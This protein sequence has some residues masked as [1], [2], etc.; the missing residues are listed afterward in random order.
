MTSW[1]A[2][3]TARV[4]SAFTL[5]QTTLGALGRLPEVNGLRDARRTEGQRDLAALSRGRIRGVEDFQHHSPRLAVRD[6]CFLA[7]YAAG[8]VPH[9]LREAVIPVFLEHRVGPSLGG[10]R[11]LDGIAESDL[12]I[13]RERVAHEDVGVGLA[14]V[15]EDLDAV[16]HAARAIPAA[17]DHPHCA[18]IELDDRDRFVLALGAIGMHLRRHLR[19]HG[20]DLRLAERPPAERDAVA[21]EVHDR[22]TPRLCDVP[23][24]GR[25]R[26]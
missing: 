20:L 18:V 24:P 2:D 12:G 13:G 6:R 8:E 5:I 26:A 15:A 19:V 3:S 22:A 11:L 21:A 9:L 17:F 4:W 23:E 14:L 10:R 1:Y 16:V 7:A 25:V